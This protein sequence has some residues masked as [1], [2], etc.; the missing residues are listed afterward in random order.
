MIARWVLWCARHPW[1]VIVVALSLAAAGELGRRGL[2]NDVVPDLSDPQIGIVADWMGHP[3]PE[4]ADAVTSV[5]SEALQ[6]VPGAKAIRGSTM[7]GMAYVDVVLESSASLDAA[8]RAIL[9][10]VDRVR[11]ELPPNVRLQIGPVASST[12]WVFEYALIDPAHVASLFELR[13]LQDEVL[14]PALASI[15]G[16]AEVASVGGARRQVRIEAKPRE[17]REHAL[18][19]TDLLDT[20][21][22]IFAPGHGMADVSLEQLEALPVVIPAPTLIAGKRASEPDEVTRIRDVARVRLTDDM[23]TG[24]ADVGGSPAVGGIVIA[25]RDADVVRLA[26]EIRRTLER[27]R[28]RL[29]HR[30]ASPERLDSGAAADVQ[31]VTVYDRSALATRVG[32]TLLGALSEEV[33][34]VVLIILIFLLHGR[35]AVVPLLTLPMVLL[36]TFGGMWIAKVPAAIMSL[37]G[38][39]IALGI[40]VDAEVVSLEASHRQLETGIPA[41]SFAPAIVTSLLITALSFLPVFAFTGETG[42]L[43]RPLAATKTL[44][45]VSAAVVTLTLAPALR[46]LLVRGRVTPEFANPL[47][48]WLVRLYR[49]F[50]HFALARPALTLV[51]AALAVA[52]CIPIASK[53]GGEFQP[54][55]DEGDLLFMPITQPGVPPEQAAMQ[56]SWQDQAMSAFAEVE[57]VFGKIGRADT[58]TDPAPYSMAET[59][60]RLRPRSQWPTF[61]RARWYSSWTPGPLRRVLGLAWPEKTPRTTAELVDALDRAVRMPGWASAWTA[62]ARARM[63]MMTTGVRTPVGIRIVSPHPERLDALG[64]ELRDI[65]SRIPGTRSAAFE[66]GGGEPWL[67]FDADHAALAREHVDAAQVKSTTELLAAGGQIGEIE[68]EGQRLRVRIAPESSDVHPRGGTDELREITVRSSSEAPFAAQPVPLALLGRPTYVTRP[69]VLRTEVGGARLAAPDFQRHELVAYVYVDLTEG[70]DVERYVERAQLEVNR[71][72][73]ARLGLQVGRGRAANLGLQVGRGRAANLRP[74]ERI[75]WTGQYDLLTAGKRRLQWIVPAVILSM[76]ALLWLQFRNFTEALIV[77]VSVPFA[78]VGSLW[79]L[80]LLSYPLSAPVWVGLLSTVGLAMQTGVVMV[81]YIDEAFHRRLREGRIATRDDIVAAHAEGTVRRLRPKLMTIT[82][83]ALALV[84][85]LWA[86]GAGAEIMRRVAAP[87]IGGLATSFLLE[88]LVYPAIYKLWKRRTEMRGTAAAPAG[89]P[90]EAL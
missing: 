42:R 43:L 87:M 60:I 14:R 58:G 63:D 57:T 53:L 39:G 71:A 35:S 18:A 19:F 5:L 2:A 83:M 30:A 6:D 8:H 15:P 54:R 90:G 47:T 49:P 72:A 10:R 36:L 34:V 40:A 12:G 31:L 69:A 4:I 50:V 89:A 61:P 81:V 33:A 78:L 86:D 24:L 17:L 28:A 73:G 88:L 77:L 7:S 74:D 25:R 56:L 85:L 68:H 9:E 1:M 51:T 21:R 65:V 59:T 23:P 29:P 37:G 45:V 84:P 13:R 70:T 48:R 16:V 11:H 62:P 75:E 79:T 26:A 32:Q 20:L 44:V 66:S 3:A 80:Y 76:L 27:E 82:T 64:R 52:S 22:P 38:I 41:Q 55:I 67:A 46:G